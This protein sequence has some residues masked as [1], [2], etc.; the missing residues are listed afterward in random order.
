[1][2]TEAIREF[3]LELGDVEETFPFDE[4]TL[5]FKTNSKMFLLLPLDEIK[6][7]F[8]VKCDPEK[9]LELREAYPDAVLPGFHMNKKHWNTIVVDG[10][11]SSKQLKEMIV[12]S[13]DLV[14]KKSKK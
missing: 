10:T 2:H 9:A 12:D 4:T 8:N 14:K 1:M 3:V 6:L 11:L 5:V 7:Q 13:Y